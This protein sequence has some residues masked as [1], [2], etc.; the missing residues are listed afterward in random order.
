MTVLLFIAKIF[1]AVAIGIIL[2]ALYMGWYLEV[3]KDFIF[4]KKGYGKNLFIILE[5]LETHSK[6]FISLHLAVPIMASFAYFLYSIGVF[7]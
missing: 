7:G 6:V 3:V 2:I 1:W 4:T 5:N